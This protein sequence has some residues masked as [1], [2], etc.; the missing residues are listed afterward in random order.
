MRLEEVAVV[1]A[2]REVRRT[3][4]WVEMV[5][6]GCRMWLM[7]PS[8]AAPQGHSRRHLEDPEVRIAVAELEG[9]DSE[10]DVAGVEAW[11]AG[12][13]RR[14]ASDWGLPWASFGL[15][16]RQPSEGSFSQQV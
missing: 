13:G 7:Q 16:V 11:L 3:R 10:E 9:E 5:E 4:C 1:I 15:S 6:V 8:L 2:V 14:A 12:D